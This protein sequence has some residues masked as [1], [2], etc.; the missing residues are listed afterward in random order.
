MFHPFSEFYYELKSNY[1]LLVKEI[2]GFLKINYKNKSPSIKNKNR[3][4]VLS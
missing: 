4:R 1:L 3:E 2:S